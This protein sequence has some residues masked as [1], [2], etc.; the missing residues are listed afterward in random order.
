LR[1]HPDI[2]RAKLGVAELVTHGILQPYPVLIEKS[3]KSI[4]VR[5]TVT[6]FV[7]NRGEVLI[8]GGGEQEARVMWV[9]SEKNTHTGGQLDLALRTEGVKVVELKK[10]EGEKMDLE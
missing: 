1:Q 8:L 2:A 9:R 7:R 10:V 6:I 3:Q 5:R 4:V